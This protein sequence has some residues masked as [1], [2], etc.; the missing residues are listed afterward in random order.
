MGWVCICKGF[1]IFCVLSFA[2]FFSLSFEYAIILFLEFS[3]LQ[4]TN[5]RNHLPPPSRF[6]P[7]S[8]AFLP[9]TREIK[10]GVIYQGLVV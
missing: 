10:E 7:L 1:S 4:K 6:Y 2:G 5:T 8:L 9:A 3:S